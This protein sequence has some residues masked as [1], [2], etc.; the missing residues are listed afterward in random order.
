MA[1]SIAAGAMTHFLFKIK[2]SRF[3]AC[4]SEDIS[5]NAHTKYAIKPIVKGKNRI[6]AVIAPMKSN[7]LARMKARVRPQAGQGMP[8]ISLKRQG[9]EKGVWIVRSKINTPMPYAIK[10]M[11]A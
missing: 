4:F 10:T 6:L 3:M 7:W 1:A 2:L 9:M 5:N 8:V 11:V